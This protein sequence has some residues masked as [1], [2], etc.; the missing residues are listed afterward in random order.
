M[1]TAQD[2]SSSDDG[3]A[4]LNLGRIAAFVG[5]LF[6]ATAATAFPFGFIRGYFIALG[7]MPRQVDR[8]RPSDRGADRSDSCNC[9]PCEAPDYQNVDARMDC[10]APRGC[11]RTHLTWR[12]STNPCLVGSA[13]ESRFA[14]LLRL[15]CH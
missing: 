14:S 3:S 2:V 8:A 10:I 6:L 9:R 15:P 4:R 1:N 11:S 13:T 12:F 5:L 7:R